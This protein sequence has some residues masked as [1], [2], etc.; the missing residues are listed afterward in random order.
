MDDQRYG[1]VSTSEVEGAGT[2]QPGELG[3]GVNGKIWWNYEWLKG[4]DRKWLFTTSSH[5][6]IAGHEFKLVKIRS[7]TNE[8]MGLLQAVGSGPARASCGYKSECDF[9][10]NWKIKDLFGLQD[11]DAWC[12]EV[13]LKE[14]SQKLCNCW[15]HIKY[16]HPT[17]IF[18]LAP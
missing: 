17:L 18:S 2:L 6:S 10:V 3:V 15:G 5:R 13:P 8:K 1:M 11:R 7:W 9:K 14:T 16:A 12:S 4:M